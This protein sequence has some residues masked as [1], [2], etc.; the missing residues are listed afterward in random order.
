[1]RFL[2]SSILAASIFGIGST[3]CIANASANNDVEIKCDYQA[4]PGVNPEFNTMNCLL[5]ETALA[6]DVPPEIV[7]AIAEKESGDWKQFDENG[8][9]IVTEDNGI[10]VMQITNQ[11]G[12]NEESLK[13]DV[14]ANIKAGVEI[15]D[16][17]FE[18]SDLP[19][20]NGK[21]RDV[22]ENWYFA[23]M[24][25]NGSKPVNSPIV[26]GT[27]ERNVDAY[28]EKVF[29]TIEDLNFVSLADIP[30]SVE[31]FDYDTNSVANIDFVKMHYQVD[32]PFTKS[33]HFFKQ[34][35]TVAS[36]DEPNIRS[37]PTTDSTSKGKLEKGEKVTIT[38]NFKYEEVAS[39][40]NHFVWYPVK[41]SNGTQGYVS[42]SYLISTFKDVPHGHYS[43]EEIRFLSD[44]GILYGIGNGNFGFEENLTRWQAVLLLIRA[45]DVSLSNR[46][47]PGFNDV[48]SDYKYY[49][50][51]AAAVDEGL[52][53]G[54]SSITFD[55]EATLTRSEMA[56]V[57]QRIYQFPDATSS[58]PFTDVKDGVWYSDSV[59]SLYD[60][61]IS[62]GI[63]STKFGPSK[64]V[65]REQF[66]VFLARSISEEFRTK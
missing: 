22:I 13:N 15:L 19:T 43:E 58:H 16:Y 9:P 17:M 32:I 55:P 1:M 35:Q 62:D 57:L 52:F 21:N 34:G 25:Y 56:E 65:T 12:Y 45:N 40:K 46:P 30:F 5:T 14:V 7:K 60:S 42:S 8:E 20:I 33:K 51:I 3:I 41:R 63:T 66:A 18:R 54:K 27:G 24:A 26:Q 48:Q 64:S 10:G 47:D 53:K 37:R 29:R 31:D 49:K 38:G 61:G 39:K 44:R 23:V 28:Q 50:E 36:T 4:Q 6:Y 59:A 2:K 11:T